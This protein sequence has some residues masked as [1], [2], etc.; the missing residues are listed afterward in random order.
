M[1]DVTDLL[2]TLIRNACV[3]DGS[4]DSGHEFRSVATLE[5]FFGMRGTIVEPRPGRQSLVYR[6]PGSTNGAPALALMSHLDVVPVNAAGWSH[7]PFGGDIDDGFVWG[8][9]AVDMLNVVAAM[10]VAFRP[11]LDGERALPGDL[12]FVAVADEEN[13]GT[14]GAEHLVRD[15]WNLVAC[16]YLLT[17]IAYPAIA[18]ASGPMPAI[19]VGE[20]GPYWQQVTARGTPGHGSQPYATSNALIPLARAVAA[21]AAEPT[22]VI[23]SDEWKRFV[24]VLDLPADLKDQLVDPDHVDEAIDALAVLD[25]NMARYAHACTHLTLTP[26]VLH[27]GEKANVIPD[28]A[29][30]SLDIR[31]LPDQDDVTVTDHLAKTLGGDYEHLEFVTMG[32]HPANASPVG[33]VLWESLLD[34]FAKTDGQREA[35]PTITPAAT[36]AR[37]WRDRGVTCY[38]AGSFCDRVSFPDFLTMFHG[39]NERVSVESLDRT[40]VL[41]AETINSFGRRTG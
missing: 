20:K 9:G 15:H 31:L 35:V 29:V 10:A 33:S 25:P 13:A 27:S 36:D 30:A 34:G 6:V 18:T 16:E 37:F 11:Y 2:S 21:L 17:E 22:P 40:A 24:A 32:E 41:L 3:N 23:I 38:G 26:T 4:P 19:T 39:N 14:Y 1:S 5:E 8:R 28:L 12:V 7:D